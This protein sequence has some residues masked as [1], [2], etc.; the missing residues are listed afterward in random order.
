[1]FVNASDQTSDQGR[2]RGA[3]PPYIVILKGQVTIPVAVREALGIRRG[4]RILFPVE[5][6]RVLI[7]LEGSNRQVVMETFPD[8]F[9]LARSVAVPADLRGAS[10]K[11]IR[12]RARSDRLARIGRGNR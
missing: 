9:A 10:W 5:D 2:R 11:T 12:R 8:F 7:E 3:L 4:T 6:E 1:M